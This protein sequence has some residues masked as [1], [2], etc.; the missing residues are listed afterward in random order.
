MIPQP[1]QLSLH[2]SK[3]YPY[4]VNYLMKTAE[5]RIFIAGGY[6]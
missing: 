1:C 5:L 2:S 3:T 6:R 4:N